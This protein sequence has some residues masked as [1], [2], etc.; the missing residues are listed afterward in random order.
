M[1]DKSMYIVY[2]LLCGD[3]SLYTGVTNNLERRFVQHQHGKASRYTRSRGVKKIVYTEECR[4]KSEALRR[5]MDI[6]KLSRQ[7][8]VALIATWDMAQES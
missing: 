4:S 3:G 5:E 2:I 6:K 1:V 8:K 7:E